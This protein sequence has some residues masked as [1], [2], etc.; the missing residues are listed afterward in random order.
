MFTFFASA[1]PT[2]RLRKFGNTR[3]QVQ[4]NVAEVMERASHGVSKAHSLAE[5]I[6]EASFIAI[7]DK[8]RIE[9]MKAIPRLESLKS[10]VTE[11]E[12]EAA[13]TAA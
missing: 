2:G 7:L 1:S 11:L 6:G 8:L 12:Q 3:T 10:L 5:Q 9:S 13:W 4:A